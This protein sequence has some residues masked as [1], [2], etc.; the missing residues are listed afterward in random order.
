MGKYGGFV[1]D[2]NERG[3]WTIETDSHRPGRQLYA[4]GKWEKSGEV[5]VTRCTVP[6][7]RSYVA[8]SVPR[9]EN[10]SEFSGNHEITACLITS[11]PA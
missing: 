10:G 11:T 6:A 7:M 5:G 8:L 1:T 9:T 3:S 2:A 4:E